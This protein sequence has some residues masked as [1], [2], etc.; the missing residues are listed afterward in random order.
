MRKL[1]LLGGMAWPS[2]ID[3]Y[4][5]ICSGV[6]ARFLAEGHTPPLPAPPMIIESVNIAETRA[7]RGVE[8]DDAS[9]VGFDAVLLGVFDRLSAAGCD[10]V[11]M[12]S[13]TPHARLRAIRDRITVP[14]ISILD[15]TAAATVESG[16]SRAL[17]LGTSVTMRGAHYPAALAAL[18][19]EAYAHLPDPEIDG[20]QRLIDTEF[21]GGATAAGRA[22]LLD[23]CARH[24][25]DARDTA[26]L[27]ACT[28]LPLAFPDHL[29][30]V[31]F[32]AE[33]FTFVNTA[34]AHIRG[35]LRAIFGEDDDAR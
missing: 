1:G 16:K 19:I 28:E 10:V 29:D 32:K 21:Y 5:A 3:Y 9:W 6:N 27:L 33:G 25:G 24:A 4:R 15:E 22:A 18:N 11:A 14:V 2:T 30:D 7:L 31:V 20:M 13:N 35:I 26:I 34:A 12:A 23:T 8:G 17:V